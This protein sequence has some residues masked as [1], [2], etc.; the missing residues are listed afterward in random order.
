LRSKYQIADANCV[1]HGLVSVNPSNK[2]MGYHT[3]WVAGFPFS[4]IGLTDKNETEIAAISRLGFNY[5]SA[6]LAAAGGRRW[7]GL[8]KA[9]VS[10]R[11][12]ARQSGMTVEEKRAALQEVY[13]RLYAR[14]RALEK[15]SNE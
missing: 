12:T 10:L 1:T 6:Y 14:Q 15:G 13:E 4:A 2:L 11:D 5:D 3:D 7:P 8:D 9:D